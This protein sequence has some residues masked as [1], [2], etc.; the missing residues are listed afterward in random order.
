MLHSASLVKLV[1][2]NIRKLYINLEDVN[3]GLGQVT[4]SGFGVHLPIRKELVHITR[5]KKSSN[6]GDSLSLEAGDRALILLGSIKPSKYQ[7]S[8]AVNPELLCSNQ[9]V[10]RVTA[11][12]IIE[13]KQELGL[14]LVLE[15][16]EGTVELLEFTNDIATLYVHA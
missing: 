7:V 8:L 5:G 9:A 13:P 11:P 10:I 12:T 1:P 14:R 6:L 4:S 15:V 3:G 2:A 16:L